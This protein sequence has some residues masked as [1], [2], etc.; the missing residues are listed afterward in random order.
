MVFFQKI[1]KL[2]TKTRM[3]KPPSIIVDIKKHIV[4]L[5]KLGKDTSEMDFWESVAP[6]LTAVEQQQLLENLNAERVLLEKKLK[7]K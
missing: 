6:H 4:A 7:S 3:P 5:R 2:L 1:K